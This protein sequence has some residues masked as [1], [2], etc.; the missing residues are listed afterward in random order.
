MNDDKPTNGRDDQEGLAV[1]PVDGT[2]PFIRPA[3]NPD[4]N[5][6]DDMGQDFYPFHFDVFDRHGRPGEGA[7]LLLPGGAIQNDEQVFRIR[8]ALHYYAQDRRERLRMPP[9]PGHGGTGFEE[10]DDFITSKRGQDVALGFRKSHDELDAEELA[11][12]PEPG[13]ATI[14][15]DAMKQHR[16]AG[17][18]DNAGILNNNNAGK[19]QCQHCGRTI[20]E[21]RLAHCRKGHPSVWDEEK[22]DAFGEDCPTADCAEV[23]VEGGLVQGCGTCRTTVW[24][25]VEVVGLDESITAKELITAMARE[26]IG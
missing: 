13:G 17:M 22:I 12:E 2:P 1:F 9:P 10:E 25:D 23:I 16:E 3:G 24:D 4:F 20:S 14:W 8:N 11:A 26:V 5:L 15:A 7:D 18:K 21:V 6:E 19:E